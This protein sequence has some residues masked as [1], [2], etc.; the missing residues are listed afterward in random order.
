MERKLTAEQKKT[1]REKIMERVKPY[2]GAAGQY[3]VLGELLRRGQEAYLAQGTTQKDWDIV[4]IRPDKSLSRISVKSCAWPLRT[5]IQIG[6]ESL[7]ERFNV[8]VIVLLNVEEPHSTRA[9][10]LVVP[11]TDVPNILCNRSEDRE[12]N[13]ISISIGKNFDEDRPELLVYEGEWGHI[14]GEWERSKP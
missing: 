14:T 13:D 11:H 3:L 1:A 10:Y 12:D 5:A 7:K 9:R 2:T 6:V 4:V 8:L